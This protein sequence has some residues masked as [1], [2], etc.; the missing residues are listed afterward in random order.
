MVFDNVQTVASLTLIRFIKSS[1]NAMLYVDK[2][3][4]TKQTREQI[5]IPI[6]NPTTP[7]KK[8]LNPPITGIS[9]NFLANFLSMKNTKNITI[10]N[11]TNAIAPIAYKVNDSDNASARLIPSSGI[12]VD[13]TLLNASLNNSGIFN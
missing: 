12:Y 8:R 11:T 3:D 13:I 4:I 5:V 7:P 9:L 2:K 1:A 10:A 6:P